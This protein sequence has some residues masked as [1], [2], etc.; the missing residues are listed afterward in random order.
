MRDGIAFYVQWSAV[1]NLLFITFLR[2]WKGYFLTIIKIWS[3]PSWKVRLALSLWQL[4]LI[5]IF[6]AIYNISFKYWFLYVFWTWGWLFIHR[7]AQLLG[8]RFLIDLQFRFRVTFFIWRWS[9]WFEQRGINRSN[10]LNLLY[11]HKS[12]IENGL[13]IIVLDTWTI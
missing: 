7:Y 13:L 10:R 5:R 12:H 4:I 6:S 9:S 8:I 3:Y 2:F 1:H 11:W